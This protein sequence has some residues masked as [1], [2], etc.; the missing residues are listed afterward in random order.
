MHDTQ[1]ISRGHIIRCVDILDGMIR[2]L[3][4]GERIE[5]A[6]VNAV[7]RF[8]SF[9]GEERAAFTEIE[10]ALNHKIGI[11]FVRSS[12]R[13]IQLLRNHIDKEDIALPEIAERALSKEEDA[14]GVAE[15][16]KNRTPAETFVSLARLENKYMR[17]PAAAA[18]NSGRG[19]LGARRAD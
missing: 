1:L 2:K 10:T 3:E 8:L 19:L 6:D 16:T 15:D 13:L 7:L 4:D 17:K 5:I 9:L 14:T 12:R 11:T 18:M